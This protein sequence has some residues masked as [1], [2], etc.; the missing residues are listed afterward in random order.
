MA[1]T[2]RHTFELPRFEAP[3]V[4]SLHRAR[5]A[6]A[7]RPPAEPA[8]A[9]APATAPAPPATTVAE[10]VVAAAS[11]VAPGPVAPPVVPPP[12]HRELVVTS[13]PARPHRD[14]VLMLAIGAAVAIGLVALVMA[15]ATGVAPEW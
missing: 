8:P 14:G 7:P 9:P 6:F 1:T 12:M 4:P 5:D 13:L 11:L 3:P 2:T 15:M 10:P